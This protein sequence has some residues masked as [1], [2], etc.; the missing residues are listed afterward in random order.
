MKAMKYVWTMVLA[1]AAII[2]AQVGLTGVLGF[3]TAE[4]IGKTAVTALCLYAVI[5]AFQAFRAKRDAGKAQG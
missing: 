5:R 1:L 4:L 2:A 3:H